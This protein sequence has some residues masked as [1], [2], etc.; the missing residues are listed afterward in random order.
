MNIHEAKDAVEKLKGHVWRTHIMGRSVEVRIILNAEGIPE[1]IQNRVPELEILE[2]DYNVEFMR[3][4]RR[5]R[6]AIIVPDVEAIVQAEAYIFAEKHND[7]TVAAGLA[8]GVK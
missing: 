1:L 6:D 8:E 7:M 5:W 3:A 2:Y 4:Y